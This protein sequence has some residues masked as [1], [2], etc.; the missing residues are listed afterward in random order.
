ATPSAPDRTERFPKRVSRKRGAVTL[1][2]SCCW[3]DLLRHFAG[4]SAVL[5][6]AGARRAHKQLA[7]V[8]EGHVAAVRLADGSAGLVLRLIAADHDLGAGLQRVP[9]D[10]G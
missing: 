5:R 3:R 8:R 4:I 7:A 2:F 6:R 1:P 9:V 10:P